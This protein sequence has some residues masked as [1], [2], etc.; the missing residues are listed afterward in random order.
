MTPTEV[1]FQRANRVIQVVVDE[2]APARESYDRLMVN[3]EEVEA[4]LR[5]GAD[6]LRPQSTALLERV[7]HAV[8]L[9]AYR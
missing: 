2:L 8:G 7:R 4:I 6:R 9:R 5:Q 3:P 1:S